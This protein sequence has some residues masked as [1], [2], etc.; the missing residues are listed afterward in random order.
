MTYRINSVVPAHI[1][2][3]GSGDIHKQRSCK[4]NAIKVESTMYFAPSICVGMIIAPT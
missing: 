1:E 3:E 4:W 2:E